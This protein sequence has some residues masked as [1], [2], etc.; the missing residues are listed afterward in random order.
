MTWTTTEEDN[1]YQ[2]P[3][4][5]CTLVNML[6]YVISREIW[7]NVCLLLMRNWG[8]SKNRYRRSLIWWTRVLLG[9]LTAIWLRGYMKEW[10]WLKDSCLTKA[11]QSMGDSSQSWDPG[12]HCTACRQLKRLDRVLFRYVSQLFWTSFRQLSWSL[13]LFTLHGCPLLLCSSWACLKWLSSLYC[14]LLGKG[15]SG[16]GQF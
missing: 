5:M 8:K 1:W 15:P 14:L 10:K 12:A 16:S 4:F 9:L 11:H 7:T 3:P 13:V 2:H 6:C